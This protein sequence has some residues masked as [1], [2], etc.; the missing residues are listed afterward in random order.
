MG[1]IALIAGIVA[2]A[3]AAVMLGLVHLRR[4]P[5]RS[6]ATARRATGM[7]TRCAWEPVVHS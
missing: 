6:R 1:Q 7:T 4:T 5:A 3:A 2:L